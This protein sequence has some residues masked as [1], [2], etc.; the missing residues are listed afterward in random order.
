M[1]PVIECCLVSKSYGEIKAV[2]GV[3]L[4][5]GQ[6]EVFGLVGPNG[7]GKTTLI[8][9]IEGLRAPD[10]GKISVLGMDPVEVPN[11]V[12]ERIGVQLQSTSI[13]PNIKVSE[14]VEL[15]ASFY[16][17]PHENPQE[18]LA[19]LSL[20]E[21]AG[22]RFRTLSGGQKQRVAIALALVND[23][24]VIFFDEISTGVDPQARRH[25]WSLIKDIQSQGKTIFLTTH[26]MEEAQ[27]LCG[28]VGILDG[29]RI[30]ALDTP[31]NLIKGL[32]AGVCVRFSVEGQV[33]VDVLESLPG[34]RSVEEVDHE[35]VLYTENENI[36]LKELFSLA[37][38]EAFSPTNLHTKKPNLDDVFLTLTGKELRE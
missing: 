32:G 8:E 29:G 18:L 16:K 4:A 17:E 2:D 28:R 6:G 9:M 10:R 35:Y 31:E 36:L 27:E 26:Y 23:P 20:K 3:S 33:S 15:F 13:Q 14:A 7:A 34:L 1:N 38:R 30:I 37:E 19:R 12:H 11:Q 21:I 24:D 22:Q 5:V 25:L